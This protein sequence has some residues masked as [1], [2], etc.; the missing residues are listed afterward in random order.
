MLTAER[1]SAPLPGSAGKRE[2]P[3]PALFLQL[4]NSL[5]LRAG[6]ESS[7]GFEKS[8]VWVILFTAGTR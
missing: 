3:Q 8:P 2:N 6:T 7:D 4:L 1:T 5:Q